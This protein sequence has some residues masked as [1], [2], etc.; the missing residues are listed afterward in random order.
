VPRYQVLALGVLARELAMSVDALVS[1]YLIDA[2]NGNED[3]FGEQIPGYRRW[4][5]P[6]RTTNARASREWPCTP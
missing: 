2:L 4:M 5:K 1:D 3:L 6:I